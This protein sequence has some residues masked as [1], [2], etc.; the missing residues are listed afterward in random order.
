[1]LQQMAG[2][3]CVARCL[4]VVAELGVAD[5][6]GEQPTDAGTLA[7]AVGAH[8]DALGR[9]L[10]LLAAHGVFELHQGRFRHTAASRLLREDHPDSMRAFVRLFGLP[11]F[12]FLGF[13]VA[14]FNSLW[15]IWSIWLAGK[16]F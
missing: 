4:H 12:G 15:L 2:G 13:M 9:V 1:M 5:A 14:F 6:L 7:T 11:L 3:Y 16:E 8:R 10:R